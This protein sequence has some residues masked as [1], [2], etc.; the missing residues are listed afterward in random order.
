[1]T[2]RLHFCIFG[3]TFRVPGAPLGPHKGTRKSTWG[4]PGAP[5]P[6]STKKHKTIFRGNQFSNQNMMTF[7]VYCGLCLYM[8][9]KQDRWRPNFSETDRKRMP[10]VHISMRDSRI[11]KLRFDCAGANES[12]SLLKNRKHIQKIH[13]FL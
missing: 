13:E 4:H 11:E 1:M 5:P 7:R 8:P 6:P 12:R 10:K 2:A 3:F 9:F